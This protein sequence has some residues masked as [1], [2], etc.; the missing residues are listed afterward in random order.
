MEENQAQEQKFRNIRYVVVEYCFKDE[1]AWGESHILGCY[2]TVGEA[3]IAAGW[4]IKRNVK[5][6]RKKYREW[7][8]RVQ[9]ERIFYPIKGSE[10]H[11]TDGIEQ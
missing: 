6:M 10:A 2:P 1:S 8:V 11:K 7:I 5:R 9:K 3:R 4:Y